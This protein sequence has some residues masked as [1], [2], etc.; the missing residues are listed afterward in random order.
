MDVVLSLT[1]NSAYQS[2]RGLVRHFTASWAAC[3]LEMV[4][5]DL[6]TPHWLGQLQELMKTRRIR[7]VFCTSGVGTNIE[8]DGVNLWERLSLPVFSLLLDHPAYLAKHHRALPASTVLGYMFEDHAQFQ[9]ASVQAENTVMSLHYGVPDLPVAASPA[10]RPRVIFAKTGNAPEALAASWREAPRL[11]RILHDALDELALTARGNAHAGEFPPVLARVCAAHHLYL[12]PFNQLQRFLLV[13]LDDYIRR[14]K[15]T[16]MA[17][18]LLRFDVDVF[19]QAWEHVDTSNA[20]A[21]FH[22]PVDY[23]TVEGQFSG[24]TASLTMNPNIDLSAH[25]RFFTAI[26]A[27]VMPV[28]DNNAYTA[29]HFPEL[30]DYTFDFRPGRLER[31]L[32]RVFARPEAARELAGACRARARGLHGVEHAATVIAETM[33]AAALAATTRDVQNFFVP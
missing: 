28:S 18:A 26:G 10:G 6:A 16:A 33:Q 2:V 15:S 31:V 21:R 13:Q 14:L 12:Q 23:A 7:F 4:E 30:A 24:A 3:G 27:G 8:M 22:G 1:W 11:E 32:E 5:L 25:D 9:A 29:R 17:R 20:R 19:G